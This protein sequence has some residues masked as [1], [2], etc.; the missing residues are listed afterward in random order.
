MRKEILVGVLKVLGLDGRIT[1]K[2]IFKQI[3]CGYGLNSSASGEGPLA[4]CFEHSSE[5][6]D[7]IKGGE[8]I[9]LLS[10]YQLLNLE[11]VICE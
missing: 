5:R 6:S 10:E 8:F 7:S 4:G 11:Q 1:L 2:C 9:D 3:L